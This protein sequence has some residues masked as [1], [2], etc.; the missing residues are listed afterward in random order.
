MK[1]IDRKKLLE[2]DPFLGE[3][4][5][6]GVVFKE[7]GWITS[8]SSYMKSLAHY[9][10]LNGGKILLDEV[11]EITANSVQTNKNHS[12]TADKII[13]CA[14]AWSGKLMKT[15]KHKTN[16]E[17]ERGYH[18]YLKGINFMP[19]NPYAVSDLKFAIECCGWVLFLTPCGS[20]YGRFC[21]RHL[22]RIER[23]IC[24]RML[25]LD[26]GRAHLLTQ[27]KLNQ[28]L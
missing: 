13:I 22:H 5:Q 21:V 12:Y 1:T 7:H 27:V 6:Y 18:L 16:L 14:G 17:T 19:Q 26:I 11:K 24:Y 25:W 28:L 23:K 4:Y 10:Q 8:P 2:K 20:S 3:K 9:F 15:I